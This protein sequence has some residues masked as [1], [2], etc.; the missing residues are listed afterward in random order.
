MHLKNWRTWADVG[1]VAVA[2]LFLGLYVETAVGGV[3]RS[4]AALGIPPGVSL[5]ALVVLAVVSVF[6]SLGL[7]TGE[8][9]GGPE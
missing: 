3:D 9:L 5:Q 1:M 8:D 7:L 2:A 6:I 4:L